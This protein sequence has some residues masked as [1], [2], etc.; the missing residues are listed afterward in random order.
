MRYLVQDTNQL[1]T[2]KKMHLFGQGWFIYLTMCVINNGSKM[3]CRRSFSSCTHS[4]T[5]AAIIFVGRTFSGKKVMKPSSC[6]IIIC[7]PDDIGVQGVY[8]LRQGPKTYFY[9]ILAKIHKKIS[10]TRYAM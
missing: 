7:L 10:C 4:C 6:L 2:S 3:C 5:I 9:P 1:R 8:L